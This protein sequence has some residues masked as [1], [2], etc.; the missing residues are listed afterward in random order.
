[1]SWL[2]TPLRELVGLFVDDV[3]YTAAILV[4]VAV[5][6]IGLPELPV[7]S[8]WDA[9]LLAAGCVL[10]LVISSAWAASRH[11]RK[12]EEA[13]QPKRGKTG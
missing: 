11:R 5:A 12:L 6:G 4:W 3:P 2:L 13:S 1:L 10:V 7:G 9:P 8:A